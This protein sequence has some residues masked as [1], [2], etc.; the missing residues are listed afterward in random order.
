MEI[1][2]LHLLSSTRIY[3]CDSTLL[4]FDTAVNIYVGLIS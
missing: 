3:I 1:S 2:D 4:K